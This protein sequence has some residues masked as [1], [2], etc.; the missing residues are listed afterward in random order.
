MSW[1]LQLSRD[2]PNHPAQPGT[3][4]RTS[5]EPNR[6]RPWSLTALTTGTGLAALTA[7]VGWTRRLQGGQRGRCQP[8]TAVAL[9]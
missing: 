1:V 7:G 4:N 8:V 5:P 9:R 3:D 2:R 6:C